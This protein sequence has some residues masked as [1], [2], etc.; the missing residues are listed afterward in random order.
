MLK[1]GY[2][3]T[4]R[5]ISPKHLQ[6]YGNGF[7]RGH[8]VRMA[9]TLDQMQLTLLRKIGKRLR[10]KDLTKANGLDSGVREMAI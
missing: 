7:S 10:Y 4:Y 6:R 9:D 2:V 8:N 1:R 3:G 5:K